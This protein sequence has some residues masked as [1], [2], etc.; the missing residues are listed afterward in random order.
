M[1]PVG[2]FTWTTDFTYHRTL[3]CKNHPTA[4]YSTKNPFERS[5]FLRKL[6]EGDIERSATGECLCPFSDLMV[7]VAES[8]PPTD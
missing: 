4:R 8:Q 6:P 5:L 2:K 7:I 1:V 3:T